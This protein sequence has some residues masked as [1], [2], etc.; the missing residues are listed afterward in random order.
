MAE[1]TGRIVQVTGGVVDVDFE[2]NPMPELFHALEIP[3]EGEEQPFILEVQSH[4]GDGWARTLAMDSTDG[5]RRGMPVIDTGAP[6]MVPV[7]EASLGR[8]FNVLGNPV[9][10]GPAVKTDLRYPI[11]RPVRERE[12]HRAIGQ[13]NSCPLS[14]WSNTFLGQFHHCPAEIDSQV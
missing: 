12:M 7:G 4:L 9:D 10:G 14:V 2:D 6:I 8:V 11:H 5:L 3:I 13:S 1:P